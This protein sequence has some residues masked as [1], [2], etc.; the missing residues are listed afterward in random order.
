MSVNNST[1]DQSIQPINPS[2]VWITIN[3]DQLGL[4]SNAYCVRRAVT[5]IE[6]ITRDECGELPSVIA[7]SLNVAGQLHTIYWDAAKEDHDP[8]II[9]LERD[10]LLIADISDTMPVYGVIVAAT[11]RGGI[12]SARLRIWTRED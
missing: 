5:D 8:G 10:V 2:S 9:R 7:V 12:L 3:I 1:A 6:R 11:P 4:S